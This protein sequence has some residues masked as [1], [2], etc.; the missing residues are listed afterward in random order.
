M[1]R[2]IKTAA[3]ATGLYFG[4]GALVYGRVLNRRFTSANNDV[5]KIDDELCKFYGDPEDQ[6]DPDDWFVASRPKD[7]EILG[8]SGEMVH[9]NIFRQKEYTENWAVV[10]HGYTS[11]PRGMA[12][13]CYYF[14]KK[15]FNVLTPSLWSFGDDPHRHCSMGWKDKDIVLDWINYIVELD[16]NA[17]I[18]VLGVSM[19]SATTMLVTGEDLPENVKCAVADCGYTSAWDEFAFQMKTT[20][21]APIFPI[22]YAANNVSKLTGNFDFKKCSPLNAV[23]KSKTPTLFIHGEKDDFVP[24]YMLGKVYNAC[25]AEKEKLEV[26]DA[27]HAE[28]NYVHPEIYYP[29]IDKFL[30][31]YFV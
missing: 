5:R 17:K 16:K 4:V 24:F 25:T 13:Q 14:Y 18:V 11:C 28:S 2:L 29:T 21:H 15:G 27:Y 31:K 20:Y 8:S 6:N 9:C 30:S 10:N 23:S 12:D 26:P 19:G 1:R 3:A 7:T 22:L